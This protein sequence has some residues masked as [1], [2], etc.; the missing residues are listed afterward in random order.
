VQVTGSS[1]PVITGTIR[2]IPAPQTSAPSSFAIFSFQS[3]GITVSEAGIPADPVGSNFWLYVES[4]GDFDHSAAGAT[5]TGLAIGNPSPL[6]TTVV[7]ELR[8]MDGHA[9]LVGTIPVPA[10][11]QAALLLN[12]I[13]DF[14]GLVTPFHGML[15]IMSLAPVTIVGL[16]MKYNERSDLLI[17]PTPPANESLPPPAGGVFFPHFAQAGGATTQFVLFDA[18]TGQ[19][20]SGTLQFMSQTGEPVNLVIQ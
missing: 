8:N 2:V 16:H 17:T 1:G 5:R 19:P 15:R 9:G 7:V 4:S 10:N 13:T 20:S 14:R 12:Q 6:P 11:G 18:Q 3:H